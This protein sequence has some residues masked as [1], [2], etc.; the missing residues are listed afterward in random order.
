MKRERGATRMCV[1]V[2]MDQ[3]IPHGTRSGKVNADSKSLIDDG[4]VGM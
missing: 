2:E 4:L 3:Y 1:C